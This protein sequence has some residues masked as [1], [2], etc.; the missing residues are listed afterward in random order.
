MT[1]FDRS[2]DS[3]IIYIMINMSTGILLL[4]K[5]VGRNDQYNGTKLKGKLNHVAV[6]GSK[7]ISDR[8]VFS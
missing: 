8:N 2:K 4:T 3:L 6:V 7:A 1:T 5:N